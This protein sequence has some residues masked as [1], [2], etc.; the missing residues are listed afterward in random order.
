MACNLT[1][2]FAQP[3]STMIQTLK[4][5]VTAQGGTAEGDE[6]AGTIRVPL[7]GSY[8]S[9]SYTINGQQVNIVIDHKPFLV[10]CKQIEGFLAGQL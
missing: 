9:G 2:N 3:A 5:K 1:I 7:L 4:S 10:S 8:I 6:N